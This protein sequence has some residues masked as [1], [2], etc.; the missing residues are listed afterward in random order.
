MVYYDYKCK[1]IIVGDT[2]VG[3][4]SLVKRY[5]LNEYDN[6]HTLTIGVELEA[7]NTKIDNT[8]L[9][10]LLWDTAGQEKFDSITSIYYNKCCFSIISFDV[11]CNESFINAKFKWFNKIK[12]NTYKSSI[13]ILVGMKSDMYNSREVHINEALKFADDNNIEYIEISS[14]ECNNTDKLFETISKK[15]KELID[16]STGNELKLLGIQPRNFYKAERDN[17]DYK[18][19]CCILS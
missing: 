3:K 7:F 8:H 12:K 13:K 15:I 18:R 6:I 5:V 14:K 9:K 11:T 16:T 17:D 2:G 1:G 4:S 10:I 19:E